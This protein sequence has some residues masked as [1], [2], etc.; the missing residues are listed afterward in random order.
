MDDNNANTTNRFIF[1]DSFYDNLKNSN[2]ELP[3]QRDLLAPITEQIT[4]PLETKKEE[5]IVE[6]PKKVKIEIPKVEEI[7][8]E[9]MEIHIDIPTIQENKIE[10]P[11]PIKVE[12]IE[13]KKEEMAEVPKINTEIDRSLEIENSI[14]Q[15]EEMVEIPKVEEMNT[16]PDLLEVNTGIDKSLESEVLSFKKEEEPIIHFTPLEEKTT[17]N[18]YRAVRRNN[19]NN[20]TNDITKEEEVVPISNIRTVKPTVPQ[21]IDENW[22]PPYQ[23]K[24]VVIKEDIKYYEEDTTEAVKS[25][26][27]EE[28]K[29]KEAETG[30]ISIL[31]RYGD[32]FCSHDYITNP[33]IGRNNEIKELDIILLTPEKS[34]ILVGKPGIGKTSIVEGLAYKLQRNQVPEALKGYTIISVKTASLLGSLPNGETRLQT[35]V[36]ELQDLDK[37]ILFIDEIHML[38]EASDESN[39]DFANL[40]K[41][42]LGRGSIKMIGAT[43]TEEYERYILRDKAFVRRFQRIDVL[44]PTKDETVEIVLGTIPKIEKNT[45][46]KFT[47]THYIQAEIVRYIVD[48]TSEYKR[49]YGIGSRYPDICL[50]ILTQ[51]FSEAR[52]DNRTEVNIKDVRNA[53]LKS[54]NIYPDVIKKEIVNFDTQFKQ[55]LDEAN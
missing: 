12:T 21:R 22:V 50:T 24:P 23:P 51:A 53:I 14:N 46:A 32:D 39:L 48:I 7:K 6:E 4:K 1:N 30:K 44:E 31:A 40:F 28:L 2:N 41:E 42:S 54:K 49:V 35:L 15:S 16:K 29:K 27:I 43:T 38:I 55:L 10:V 37:I 13:N 5:V 8:E 17:K 3:P 9:P 20:I 45:G 36:N 18:V 47:Y 26:I 52:F 25:N 33:A 34:A 19:I 11:E